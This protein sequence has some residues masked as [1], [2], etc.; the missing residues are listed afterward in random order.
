MATYREIAKTASTIAGVKGMKTCW[1]AHVSGS[2]E[3]LKFS[4]RC[5]CNPNACQIRTMAFCDR[6]ISWAMR[7]VPQCVLLDGIVSSVLVTRA[8][9]QLKIGRAS[10]RERV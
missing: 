3:N 5:G 2:L 7:R 9:A 8:H 4:T 10:C 1:I 6:P